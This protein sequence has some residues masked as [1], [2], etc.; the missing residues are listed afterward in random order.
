MDGEILEEARRNAAGAVLEHFPHCAVGD[1]G[2]RSE[3]LWGGHDGACVVA[4]FAGGLS[5]QA[6]ED[7]SFELIA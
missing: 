4:A 3:T 6:I 5:A 2:E 7:V 1:G